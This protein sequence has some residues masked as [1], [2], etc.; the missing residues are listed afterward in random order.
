MTRFG[1]D[2]LKF[3]GDALL[4][5]FD[6]VEHLERASATADG[7]RRELRRVGTVPV[8][9]KT[10][11]LRMSQGLHTGTFDFFLVGDSH[12]ELV[13]AGAAATTTVA[14]ESAAA[15]QEV[16]VSPAAAALLDPQYLGGPK[17]GGWLLRAA[18]PTGQMAGTDLL[19]LAA[20]KQLARFVPLA[21][22]GR[23]DSIVEESEHRQATVA[24][25]H[26]LG[27]DGLLAEQGAAEVHRRLHS[28]TCAVVAAMAQFGVCVLCTDIGPDGGKFMLVSGAPEAHEDAEE[29]MLRAARAVLDVDHG[30]QVRIG[31]NRGAVYGGAV[32]GPTRFTY[33]T[34]GDAVNLAAR[35]MGKAAPGELLATASVM[36]HCPDRFE[37]TPL[38]PFM[39]KGKSQP[40]HALSVGNPLRRARTRSASTSFVGRQEDLTRF[41]TAFAR[42]CTGQGSVIEIVADA[43]V[44]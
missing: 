19:Q 38:D 31:V 16:L 3:G 32:G 29:R 10:V 4:I 40:V 7:M 1:G 9:N 8:G 14:M 18:P 28:L 37:A 23:L 11:T 2:V 41:S 33:S 15:A 22:R 30:L 39:V 27:V 44:G 34:M 36:A 26:F 25:L 17:E 5:F 13:V 43:G 12:S 35:V 24:F 20:P 6:G 42:A 21:L